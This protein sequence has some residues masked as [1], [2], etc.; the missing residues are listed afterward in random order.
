MIKILNEYSLL[1]AI[2]AEAKNDVNMLSAYL[3][4]TDLRKNRPAAFCAGLREIVK[5]ASEPDCNDFYYAVAAFSADMANAAVVTA[6]LTEAD[7]RLCEYA[8]TLPPIEEPVY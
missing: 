3:D 7:I 1:D 8:A 5:M 2:H 4:L 6:E